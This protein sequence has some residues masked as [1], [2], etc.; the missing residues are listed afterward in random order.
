MKELL[1][2][3][4]AYLRNTRGF[5]KEMTQQVLENPDIKQEQH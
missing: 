5:S 4:E 1:T 3:P 2:P